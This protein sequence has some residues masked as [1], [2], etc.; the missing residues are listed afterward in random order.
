[1]DRQVCPDV[2]GNR[3]TKDLWDLMAMK[4][5]PAL[6]AV[7][8]WR[9]PMDRTVPRDNKVLLASAAIQ[10]LHLVPKVLLVR[11]VRQAQRVPRETMAFRVTRAMLAPLALTV[12]M[13]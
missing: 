1:M 4:V 3:G 12:V 13:D 5:A 2:T 7:K 11:Q 6:E 8:E 9:A 10:L